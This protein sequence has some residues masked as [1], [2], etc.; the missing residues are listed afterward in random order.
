VKAWFEV[1]EIWIDREYNID[2]GIPLPQIS[3]F[4]L[5]SISVFDE[6][7]ESK[8]ECGGEGGVMDGVG[9]MM[10]AS[11]WITAGRGWA[12]DGIGVR[13]I[14]F[15]SSIISVLSSSICE[16]LNSSDLEKCAVKECGWRKWW[17]RTSWR[18]ERKHLRMK[19]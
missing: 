17:E 2:G 10:W 4:E 5:A 3:L 15:S 6:I 1:D 11:W 13:A 16:T 12:I 9:G 18:A 14:A 7:G 19:K 8:I